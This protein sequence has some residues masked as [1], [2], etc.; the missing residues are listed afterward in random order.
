MGGG[1]VWDALVLMVYVAPS[2][3]A[4]AAAGV[5]YGITTCQ[6]RVHTRTYGSKLCNVFAC[7]QVCVCVC[8]WGRCQYLG[9]LSALRGLSRP[10]WAVYTHNSC[11]VARGAVVVLSGQYY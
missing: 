5:L 11:S 1:A 3:A 8:A 4:A 10:M 6:W 2:R 7:V 9:M